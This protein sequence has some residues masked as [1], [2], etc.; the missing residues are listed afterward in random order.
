MLWKPL[1]HMMLGFVLGLS[2]MSQFRLGCQP[3]VV[4][5]EAAEEN[6]AAADVEPTTVFSTP[7][8]RLLQ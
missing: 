6:D 7:I 2:V 8:Q 5:G 3:T 1:I 4:D